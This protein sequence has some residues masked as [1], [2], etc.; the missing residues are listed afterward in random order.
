MRFP[1]S[2]E[3]SILWVLTGTLLATWIGA[4]VSSADDDLR[5]LY[6]EP[7]SDIRVGP[8]A[9]AA[10]DSALS[11][12]V[13]TTRMSFEAFGHTLELELESNDQLSG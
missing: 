5:I 10:E 12:S 11:R 2:E 1:R 3:M 8:A 4:G 7:L 6:H 9:R 13:P